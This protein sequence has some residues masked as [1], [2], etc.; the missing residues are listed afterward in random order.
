MRKI[1]SIIIALLALGFILWMYDHYLKPGAV[2]ITLVTKEEGKEVRC[3]HC[4]RVIS[5][6]VR[7]V[8]VTPREA[9]YHYVARERGVCAY[10]YQQGLR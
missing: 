8:R 7:I 1:K 2:D 5:R 9:P 10:C 3:R 4:G 6:E